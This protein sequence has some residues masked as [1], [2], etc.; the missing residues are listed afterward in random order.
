MSRSTHPKGFTLIEL[1]VVIAI[2]AILASMLLPALQKARAKALAANCT[3]NLKQIG[4]ASAMYSDDNES[5]IVPPG[6]GPH[7]WNILLHTYIGDLHMW[8]CPAVMTK[9]PWQA[10]SSGRNWYEGHDGCRIWSDYALNYGG[11]AYGSRKW[12]TPANAIISQITDPS[13]TYLV[14]DGHCDRT[15]PFDNQLDGTFYGKYLDRDAPHNNGTNVLFTDGHVRWQ[16]ATEIK[17]H[18]GGNLGPWTRDDKNTYN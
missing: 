1:L 16:S 15:N 8:E 6:S 17:S 14:M 11:G 12:N 5:R 2:I 4:L 3:S 13:G 18:V 7:H 9:K 10:N